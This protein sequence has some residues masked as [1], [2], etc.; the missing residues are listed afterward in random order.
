MSNVPGGFTKWQ[1]PVLL[2]RP[3]QM[4]VT[5]AEPGLK[6]GEHSHDEGDGIRFIAGG[7]IT[8]EDK[9]LSGGDWMFIPAGNRGC[10]GN[11][12]L[13]NKKLKN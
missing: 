3:S 5:V 13:E 1:L 7:S 2:T 12:P 9:E 11:Q 4:F 6:V 10:H 8:F